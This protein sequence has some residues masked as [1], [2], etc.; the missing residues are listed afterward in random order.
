M[1]WV[2]GGTFRMGDDRFYPEEAP[3]HRVAVDGFWMET[4][5]VTNAQFRRFVAATD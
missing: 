3:V 2:P 1:V 5:A 4:R